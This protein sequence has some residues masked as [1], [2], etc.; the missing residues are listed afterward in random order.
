VEG[1]SNGTTK[2][3]GR[4]REEEG[5]EEGKGKRSSLIPS[6]GDFWIRPWCHCV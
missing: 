2:G 4:K 5:M 1:R 6:S 3:E